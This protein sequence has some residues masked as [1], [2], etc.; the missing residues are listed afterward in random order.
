MLQM[1]QCSGGDKVSQAAS[2]KRSQNVLEEGGRY[3][4]VSRHK[5]VICCV[6]LSSAIGVGLST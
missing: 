1:L 3:E 4:S 5:K 6:R 2:G